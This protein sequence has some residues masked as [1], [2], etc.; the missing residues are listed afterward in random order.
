MP[1]RTPMTE[2]TD[3]IM[4][5]KML[6][7]EKDSEPGTAISKTPEAIDDERS[8]ERSSDYPRTLLIIGGNTGCKPPMIIVRVTKGAEPDCCREYVKN[9]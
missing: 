3:M 8:W 7:N 9:E 2:R 5:I 1:A 6:I 4:R